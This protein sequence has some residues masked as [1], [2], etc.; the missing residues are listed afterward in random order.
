M[1][2]ILLVEGK[3][4]KTGIRPFIKR[5]LDENAL[6]SVGITTVMIKNIKKLEIRAKMDLEGP[7]AQ[8]IVAVFGLLDIYNAKLPFP[9]DKISVNERFQWGKEYL[10]NKIR[11]PKFKMFFAVHE[12][13]A[14]LLSQYELFPKKIQKKLKATIKN[15]PESVDLDEPP[16]KLLGK[17]YK[18]ELGSK[19]KKVIE[20]KKMF[21]KLDPQIARDKCPYLKLMLDEMLVLAKAALEK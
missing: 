11:H 7:D 9:G 13:E 21:T 6:D 16:G 2:F 10:E 14:W 3:T 15:K 12:I 20:G 19:Y 4:E 17:L 1:R 8:G 5:W 18:Q